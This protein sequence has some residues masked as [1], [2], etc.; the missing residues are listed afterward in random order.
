VIECT[1]TQIRRER[2]SKFFVSFIMKSISFLNLAFTFYFVLR[3]SIFF[4]IKENKDLLKNEWMNSKFFISWFTICFE[5]ILNNIFSGDKILNISIGLHVF[6]LWFPLVG[7]L[8]GF[9]F[10]LKKNKRKEKKKKIKR[11]LLPFLI[12][13][14]LCLWG[15]VLEVFFNGRIS[16]LLNPGIRIFQFFSNQFF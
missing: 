8:K 15:S 6:F 11:M 14:S 2:V 12:N 1:K 3:K 10:F 5:R 16:S 13:I 9:L 7:L 4:S